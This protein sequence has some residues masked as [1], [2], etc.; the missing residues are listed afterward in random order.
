MINTLL[1]FPQFNNTQSIIALRGLSST[2]VF[3][4]GEGGRNKIRR[5][6]LRINPNHIVLFI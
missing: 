2:Y 3:F 1:Y 6:F 5:D 4:G